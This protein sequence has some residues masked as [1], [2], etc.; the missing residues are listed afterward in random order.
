LAL[1]AT[2]TKKIQET[3]LQVLSFRQDYA[4]IEETPNR[5]NI[6]LSKARIGKNLKLAFQFL[7][8]KLKKE[9]QD[10]ERTIVYCKSIKQCASLYSLFRIELGSDAYPNDMEHKSKNCLF[11]MFH[12]CTSEII[13]SQILESLHIESG[14]CRLVFATNALGMGVN[15]RDI[16]LVIHL[17][18][19]RN[20]DDYIQEIG[21]AGRDGLPSKAV[22]FYNGILLKGAD[23][24]MQAYCS[25]ETNVCMRR[26]LLHDFDPNPIQPD[27]DHLCCLHCHKHCLCSGNCC[28]E[29][30]VNCHE[31]TESHVDS[32]NSITVKERSVSEKINNY[33]RTF[34]LII[35]LNLQEIATIICMHSIPQ[36][37]L[38]N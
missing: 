31:T 6:Y 2:A 37:S 32:D 38:I 19:P 33:C 1:T 30:I 36:V 25:D 28:S 11:G 17:G 18:P 27:I 4:L 26:T 14:V 16:R 22:M 15:F 34:W 7:L 20:I 9:K 23:D 35:N 10:M 8:D 29:E 21:R 3:V 24:K 13:K 12:H 5:T